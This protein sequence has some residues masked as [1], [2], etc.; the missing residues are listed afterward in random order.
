MYDGLVAEKTEFNITRFSHEDRDFF[1]SMVDLV[2]SILDFP[3]GGI[4]FSQ[5][6]RIELLG[7]K[8]LGG[9]G[10]IDSNGFFCSYTLAQDDFFFIQDA[11]LDPRFRNSMLVNNPPF[12]NAYGGLP[13]IVPG[14]GKVGTLFVADNIP[15]KLCDKSID[16]LKH[17]SKQIQT[18]ILDKYIKNSLIEKE[19]ES[20]I[21]MKYFVHDLKSPIAIIKTSIDLLKSKGVVDFKNKKLLARCQNSLRKV[22][23]TI[24]ELLVSENIKAENVDPNVSSV[25]LK[26]LLNGVIKQMH[27]LAIDGQTISLRCDNIEVKTDTLLLSRVIENII[28]NAIKYGEGSDISLNIFQNKD[29]IDISISDTGVGIPDRDKERVFTF[30]YKRGHSYYPSHGIGLHFCRKAMTALG[31]EVYVMDNLPKGTT[32]VISLPRSIERISLKESIA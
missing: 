14:H 13:L 24:N 31:G 19:E 9:I 28:S 11:I 29:S 7:Q 6:D 23:L 12:F 32:F 3:M 2:S 30:G 8:G 10:Q 1:D 20:M 25:D 15:R 22:S 21:N 18:M 16:I 17:F 4:C 26:D 5:G 27:Y